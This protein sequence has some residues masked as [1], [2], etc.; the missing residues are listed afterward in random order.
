MT[1]AAVA[2]AALLL[3]LRKPWALTMPQLW[4]EDGP[5]HLA[6][7]DSW[8]TGAFLVP[9]RGYLHLLPRLIAWVASHVAD[10][11]HWPLIYNAT[12]F[13]VAVALL[14]RFASKRLDLPAKPW[15]VLSFAL[16]AHT[17]E[18]WFNI[19]NLHWLTS[20]FLVQQVLITR[21]LTRGQRIGDLLI[22]AVVGLTGPFVVVLLPLLFW[23][24]WR[25]R[26]ADNVVVLLTAAACAATQIYFLTTASLPLD[27]QSQPLN[28]GMLFAVIGSRLVV[29]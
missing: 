4:A 21:P 12:A 10:V 8:G 20:F 6:D 2:V 9:Y 5:I 11:A 7:I 18:V 29:W 16:A 1:W 25:D 22:L 26:H 24:W 14:A 23:R 13:L 3:F 28:P 27:A 19:T 17:G 15:L